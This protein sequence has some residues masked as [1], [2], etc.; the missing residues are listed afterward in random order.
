M[1]NQKMVMAFCLA[2]LTAS[3]L[4]SADTQFNF[5]GFGT[6]A[7]THNSSSM[8]DYR[9]SIVQPAGAGVSKPWAFGVDSKAGAQVTA[10]MGD[11]WSAVVQVVAD[12]HYD[13]TYR[14]QFE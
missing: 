10:N 12:H 8:A 2:G 14:P 1:R 7:A 3:G 9:A 13:N 11:G 5:S 6:L 4:A